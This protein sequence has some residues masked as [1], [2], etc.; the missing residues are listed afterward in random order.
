MYRD[1]GTR[2]VLTNQVEA[3]YAHN[4]DLSS[5]KYCKCIWTIIKSLLLLLNIWKKDSNGGKLSI[6][7]DNDCL[8]PELGD[9]VIKLCYIYSFNKFGFTIYKFK[10]WGSN[11]YDTKWVPRN[12]YNWRNYN[13]NTKQF[14]SHVSWI[15]FHCD[16]SKFDKSFKTLREIFSYLMQNFITTEKPYN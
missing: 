14:I 3:D 7:R 13:W 16:A 8:R 11:S 5:T 9:Q 12:G 2:F 6:I 10:W 4:L 15:L 1:I